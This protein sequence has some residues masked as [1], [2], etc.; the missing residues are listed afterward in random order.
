MPPLRDGENNSCMF[1]LTNPLFILMV[2]CTLKR[3]DQFI[4]VL[5]S[6]LAEV[7]FPIYLKAGLHRTSEIS[8]AVQSCTSL[9]R[10]V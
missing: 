10:I 5:N 3:L 6:L 1:N 9:C 8:S 4:K 7:V 2:L